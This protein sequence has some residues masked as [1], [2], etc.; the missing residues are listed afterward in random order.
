MRRSSAIALGFVALL[1]G[2]VAVGA[3]WVNQGLTATSMTEPKLI[4]FDKSTPF[5]AAMAR[6]EREGVIRNATAA[7]VYALLSRNQRAV[8]RGTYEFKPGP[9][10]QQI[11]SLKAPMRRMVRLPET[12]WARRSAN[13][14]EKN[15]VCSAADYMALVAQPQKFAS[16]FDFPMPDKTLEGYLYPDTY[17]LPPLTPAEDVIRMQLRNFQKRV[18]E[19]LEKPKNLHRAVTVGSLVELEVARDD[20]RPIVAGVVENRLATGMRLQ[21]DAAIN[22]GLQVWRPLLRSEYQS[23]DSPYNLY[24]VSGLPPTPICSPTVKSIAAALKPAKHP[25]FYYVALPDGSSLFSASYDEH[26]QNIGKR[27]AAIKALEGR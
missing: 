1:A 5:V 24:R 8:S 23:V 12:N 11:A 16:D 25:Y 26:L 20:E 10:S 3:S 22:Y 15:D 9:T 21:I 7:R 18:W 2:G 14:L 17:D 6:L 13:L 4:R 27:R 19:G